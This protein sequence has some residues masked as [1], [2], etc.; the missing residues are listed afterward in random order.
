MRAKF[1]IVLIAASLT[2]CAAVSNTPYGHFGSDARGGYEDRQ[3]GPTTFWVNF[4]ANGH[5]PADKIYDFTL[6]RASEIAVREGKKLV[7][8]RDWK[9]G[10]FTT[11]GVVHEVYTS[12]GMITAGSGPL[13]FIRSEMTFDTA[14]EVEPSVAS[15]HIFVARDELKRLREKYGIREG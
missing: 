9:R 15:D 6:L 14:D 1:I 8:I 4:R 2:S 7:L 12:T 11:A 5:T 13:H 10:P 3:L